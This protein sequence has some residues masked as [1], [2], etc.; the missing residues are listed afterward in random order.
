MNNMAKMGIR[1]A[2]EC[3]KYLSVIINYVDLG[4]LFLR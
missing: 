2:L 4:L 3:S 1:K